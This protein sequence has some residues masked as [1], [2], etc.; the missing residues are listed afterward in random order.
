MMR[1]ITI[2]D[3][4]AATLS[5]S[6]STDGG[7]VPDSY[8]LSL[9]LTVTETTTFSNNITIKFALVVYILIQLSSY[10]QIWPTRGIFRLFIFIASR[11]GHEIDSRSRFRFRSQPRRVNHS[12]HL[13]I[14][15]PFG[16]TCFL[17]SLS[18][19]ISISYS[20]YPQSL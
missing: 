3:S 10:L 18:H 17:T 8:T 7:R 9:S 6:S 16:G 13:N 19:I 2:R 11:F 20:S 4:E 5:S 1:G 12:T 15:F 14:F